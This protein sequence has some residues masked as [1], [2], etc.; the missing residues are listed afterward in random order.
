MITNIGMQNNHDGM[1][2]LLME[3]G[4]EVDG[5]DAER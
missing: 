5:D 3:V 2:K 1:M 4:M